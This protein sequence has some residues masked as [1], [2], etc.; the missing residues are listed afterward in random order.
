MT[1]HNTKRPRLIAT[2][3]ALT[4]FL[5][6]LSI[7]PARSVLMDGFIEFAQFIGRM[8]CFPGTGL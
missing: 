3:A 2:V 8:G 4:V 5:I 7:P 1:L 6:A